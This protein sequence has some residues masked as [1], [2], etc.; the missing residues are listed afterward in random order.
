MKNAL[1]RWWYETE[2]PHIRD[3]VSVVQVGVC[4]IRRQGAG[5]AAAAVYRVACIGRLLKF[6]DQRR[7][8]RVALFGRIQPLLISTGGARAKVVVRIDDMRDLLAEAAHRWRWSIAVFLRRHE[9]RSLGN[10]SAHFAKT[11]TH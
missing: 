11:M 5:L 6:L 7:L 10:P 2:H 9:V 8:V 1:A 4:N 3:D